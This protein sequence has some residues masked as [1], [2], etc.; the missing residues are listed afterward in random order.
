LYVARATVGSTTHI[1]T[2]LKFR[3]RVWSLSNAPSPGE[4]LSA[5]RARRGLALL[6]SAA[7]EPCRFSVLG[8]DPLR[9][10][11]GDHEPSHPI[12]AIEELMNG[13]EFIEGDEIPGPFQGGFIGAISYDAGVKGE[14]L[15]LPRDAW[16]Q[17]SWIGGLYTDFL[18]WDHTESAAWLVLGEE[19]GDDRPS[20][21]LR[22]AAISA[23]LSEAA[24]AQ[25][26]GAVAALKRHTSVEEHRARIEE[27]RALIAEG[28]IYQAN[29]A[30]RFTR[31]MV[32][33]PV[34]Q[35][36]ALREV[37]AAPYMGYL[38]SGDGERPQWALL[39]ASPE[40]LLEF[41]GARA[42][43]RPIKGTAARGAD[44]VE[45]EER[46]R[47]L[48]ESEKDRA[49]LAM[50]VDLARNDL[51]RV[52]RPGSVRVDE[53]PELR[54]YEGIHHLMADVTAEVRDGVDSFELLRALFPGGSIT[55]APKLRVMEAIKEIEREGRG[56]FTGSMGYASLDGSSAW[57]ILIRTLVWRPTGEAGSDFG[58]LSF[59]V[60]GGITWGSDAIEEEKETLLKG[61]RLMKVLE[62]VE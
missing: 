57:N 51:G 43:T 32:G 52:A 29:I 30:H 3:P 12:D 38:A 40:L 9:S 1:A 18:V 60:G 24:S 25:P 27:A 35:Y 41:D 46:G 14:E 61:A 8:F 6:D 26:Y 39:S 53:F 36:L 22:E 2:R 16:V 17:P 21:D 13:L 4:A 23:S 47:A 37:N 58:E 56:F 19:P 7:G 5:L 44:D 62:G 55:G 59:H 48:M 34:D 54:S 42:T 33:S 15:G 49:E 31:E 11:N 50:I 10:G 28:E 20:V 45:D